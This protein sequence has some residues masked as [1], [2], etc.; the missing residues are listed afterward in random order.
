MK[1]I[2]GAL[3]LCLVAVA[4]PSWA[5]GGVQKA[6]IKRSQYSAKPAAL[7]LHSG[8][9]LVLDQQSGTPLFAKNTDQ[10][11]PIASITKLMTA[12]VVLDSG[13]PLLE[14]ISVD[15]YDVA[16]L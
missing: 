4:L 8:A 3:V 15:N 1:A 11:M 13:L 6:A 16:R 7:R 14:S 9:V 2:I 10:V 5:A 12:M